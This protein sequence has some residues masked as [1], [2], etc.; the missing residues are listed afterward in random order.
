MLPTECTDL[1]IQISAHHGN[2]QVDE[3]QVAAFYASLDPT[4]SFAEA[5]QAVIEFY[6]SSTGWMT[7]ADVNR[8]VKTFRR[9]KMPSE[10]AVSHMIEQAGITDGDKAWQYRRTLYQ[11][12][13]CGVSLEQAQERALAASRHPMLARVDRQELTAGPACGK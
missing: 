7:V 3:D 12:C 10:D 8:L 6:R 1:M 13:G 5:T 2:A 9:R 11:A 4:I